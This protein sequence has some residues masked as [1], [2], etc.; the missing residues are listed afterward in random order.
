MLK[1]RVTMAAALVVAAFAGSASA[2]P[3]L[4]FSSDTDTET[5]VSRNLTVG[6]SFTTT[7]SFSVTALDAFLTPAT[8]SPFEV[9]PALVQLYDASSNIL[10]SATVTNSDPTEG[11]PTTFYSATLSTPVV[12]AANTTYYISESIVSETNKLNQDVIS[13]TTSSLITYDIGIS[14]LGLGHTPITN[15]IGEDPDLAYFGPNF[16][17]AAIPEP[18]SLTLL[19]LGMAG[20]G[21]IRRRKR[22]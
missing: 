20:L 1:L 2:D 18:A 15:Q 4:E 17:V 14:A 13:L 8:F 5:A 22:T 3:V 9:E 19:G 21:V 12:L 10:A 7:E 11:N 16:D 6:W